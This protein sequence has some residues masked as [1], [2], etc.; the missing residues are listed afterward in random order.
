MKLVNGFDLMEFAKNII[1][2]YRRLIR[3]IWK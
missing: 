1:M 2:Y 3:Q